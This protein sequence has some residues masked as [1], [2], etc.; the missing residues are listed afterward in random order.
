M[1]SSY[2]N[3][4]WEKCN[5]YFQF[6][7][8]KGKAGDLFSQQ[9]MVRASLVRLMEVGKTNLTQEMANET[10]RRLVFLKKI[11]MEGLASDALDPG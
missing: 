2:Q 6:T 1:L 9:E 11:I 4:N 7:L 5:P 3:G 10:S 8:H